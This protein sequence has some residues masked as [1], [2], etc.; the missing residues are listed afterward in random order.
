MDGQVT[1]SPGITLAA[2][3]IPDR[4]FS[5]IYK[6]G[7]ALIAQGAKRTVVGN[8]SFEYHAGQYLVVPV[9]LPVVAQVIRA[10]RAEP[11]LVFCLTLDPAA[12]A[13]LLLET[14]ADNRRP[15]ESAGLAVSDAS[16]ELVDAVSRLIRLIDHPSD[17]AVLGPMLKREILWRLLSGEQG[18]IVRQIGLENSHLSRIARAIQQIRANYARSLSIEE[19]AQVAGMSSSSFHRHFRAVTAMSPLQYQK[20]IRLQEART[21]LLTAAT[22]VAAVGFDVGYDNPSQFSREY[23]RLFGVSPGKDLQTLRS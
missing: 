6:P 21:R 5:A 20:Q 16:K 15:V 14:A 11:Y 3:S 8:K 7:V 19:L 18:A 22:D 12:I 1:P 13:A 23:S 10:S 2:T 4:T 9:S 17:M